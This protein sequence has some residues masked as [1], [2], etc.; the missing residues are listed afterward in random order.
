MKKLL[1]FSFA[2][3]F[4][5]TGCAVEEPTS[6]EGQSDNELNKSSNFPS[7]ILLPD[8]FEPEGIVSGRGTT[9]Y[10][11]SLA[12]GAIY[13]GD[14]RT[15][16]GSILVGAS[17][18]LAFGLSYD[19]RSGYLFVAGGPL[20]SLYVYNGSTGALL[21]EYNIP[22][23]LFINDVVVTK[24]AVYLSE[25]LRPYIYKLPLGPAGKLPDPGSI[26]ELALTG[27][28]QFIENAPTPFGLNNN[29]I[30]TTPNGK[31]L[32]VGNMADGNLYR[33]DAETGYSVLIQ[34]VNVPFNDGLLLKGKTLYVV[35]NI[36][37]QVA[38]VR[39]SS[40]LLSGSLER[41]ITNPAFEVPATI[42]S[43][44]NALY[45]VNARFT[46]PPGPFYVVKFF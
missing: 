45:V 40:D 22:T 6:Y 35:Q 24:N 7:V 12:T 5:L 29:G 21:G 32:I 44:G 20:G 38:E 30:E 11:G 43:F 36:I 9:F 15:G 18:R 46:L 27:D 42:T 1:F 26:Q 25:S 28:Y 34:G 31:Y 3:L 23:A 13:K 10:V 16:E 19:E 37:S 17:S 2:L 14:F 33:V 8:G 41:V 4:L 39:L